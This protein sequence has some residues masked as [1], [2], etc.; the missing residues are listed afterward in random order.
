MIIGI[1]GFG[2]ISRNLIK[3][4]LNDEKI[5]IRQINYYDINLEHMKYLL[6]FDSIYGNWNIDIKIIEN[7]LILDNKEIII[8][9]NKDIKNIEWISDI[10]CIIET[11]G[12]Y[13]T[14]KEL[15]YHKKKVIL[16]CPPK[17]LIIPI[18]VYGVNH[19][20]SRYNKIISSASCTTNALAPLL[21]ILNK[22]FIIETGYVIS[23]HAVTNSQSIL[24]SRNKKNIKRGRSLF[25]NIIPTT[26]GA[27]ECINKI[28]PELKNKIFCSA[29]RVPVNLGSL[30][31]ITI[32]LKKKT[33]LQEI[34]FIWYC[35]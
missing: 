9:D 29:I 26:T 1:N 27:S 13:K 18:F 17:D 3:L 35:F 21:K 8:S 12:I 24:D 10:N 4:L 7:K 25:N 6:L 28:L 14:I 32:L 22:N 15:K 34:I 2:R 19:T 30:L 11:T 23:I 31:D 16:S 20:C 5:I 33:T